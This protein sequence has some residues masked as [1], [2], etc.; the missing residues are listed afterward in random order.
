M[1]LLKKNIHCKFWDLFSQ[2]FSE[3]NNERRTDIA[4]R[5]V[6]DGFSEK[7][8]LLKLT[9]YYGA[10]EISGKRAAFQSPASWADDRSQY[11]DPGKYL[12]KRVFTTCWPESSVSWYYNEEHVG[13]HVEAFF[14]YHWLACQRG[15]IVDKFISGFV[16]TLERAL[17]A[18]VALYHFYRITA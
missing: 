1:T 3:I 5:N 17:L 13:D 7:T 18:A 8:T 15:F 2:R 6:R 14:G 4:A 11:F 9:S 10:V 16:E 12:Y